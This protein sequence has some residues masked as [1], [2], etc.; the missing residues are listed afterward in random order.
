[1]SL[2]YDIDVFTK[3]TLKFGKFVL[4]VWRG[5][6]RGFIYGTLTWKE[7][8]FVR[9]TLQTVE[10]W[11]SR[12]LGYNVESVILVINLNFYTTCL[13]FRDCWLSESIDNGSFVRY[14]CCCDFLLKF[15]SVNDEE[16]PRACAEIWNPGHG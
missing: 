5:G 16:D 14:C 15:E 6:Q 2:L 4:Y 10:C 7:M 1:M 11:L 13:V 9:R 8:V 3:V 12:M